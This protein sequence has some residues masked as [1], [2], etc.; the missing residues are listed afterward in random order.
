M[1]DSELP[2]S[3]SLMCALRSYAEEDVS[4]QTLRWLKNSAIS[5]CNM[6]L[7]NS[8]GQARGYIAWADISKETARR[9]QSAGTYPQY[10]Y[11]WREGKILLILD[12]AF[13]PS[14]RAQAVST[15]RDLIKSRRLVVYSYRNKL[16]IICNSK[17]RK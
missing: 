10:V 3:F 9:L 15:L 6:F 11:E 13:D 1:N 17:Q 8:I 5:E 12:I 4:T 7:R 16:K 2:S 14:I